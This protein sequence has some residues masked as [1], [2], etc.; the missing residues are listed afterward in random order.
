MMQVSAEGDILRFLADADGSHISSIASVIQREEGLYF[1][2]LMGDYIG[3]LSS[4][5][6]PPM[7][8]LNATAAS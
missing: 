1:G 2:N 6:L 8:P 5:L 4:H 3:F 7:F